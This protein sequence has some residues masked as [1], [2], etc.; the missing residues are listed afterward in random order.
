MEESKRDWAIYNRKLVERGNFCLLIKK[1]YVNS[2]DAELQKMNAGK[3]GRPYD[4][5]D[6]FIE[7]VFFLKAAFRLQYRQLQGFIEG[8]CLCTK[9]SLPVPHFT[10]PQKRL[11]TLDVELRQGKT[12][13]P[14]AIAIDSSGVKLVNSGEW[15]T[16]KYGNRKAWI[17]M[18]CA[19][20]VKNG[21]VLSM[22]VTKDSI[23]DNREF[24]PLLKEVSK[25]SQIDKVLADGAYDSGENF[26]YLQTRG[27]VAGIKV[28]RSSSGKSK[29]CIAR[30]KAVMEQL[31]FTRAG[32][33]SR[34]VKFMCAADVAYAKWR[35]KVKYGDRWR[36][37]GFFGAFKGRYG[38]HVS[39]RSFAYIEKELCLK[40]ELYNLQL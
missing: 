31:G 40:A 15:R 37:E 30:K 9:V 2:L 10:T 21:R 17:K 8:I 12:E 32:R 11:G 13:E 25:S 24:L 27:I 28:R 18:H 4:Y 22:K 36:V 35:E 38:E 6:S 34:A 7:A 14:V 29:G 16:A 20:D 26:E 19:V 1:A 3:R 39:S 33:R 5:P 23:G